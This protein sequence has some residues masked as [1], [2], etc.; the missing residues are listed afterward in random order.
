LLRQIEDDGFATIVEH[1]D[2]AMLAT[3]STGAVALVLTCAPRADAALSLCRGIKAQR[4][5]PVVVRDPR[6]APRAVRARSTWAPTTTWPE[7]ASPRRGGGAGPSDS[8]AH[9]AKAG[10]YAR[11]RSSSTWTGMSRHSTAAR[12]I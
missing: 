12:S 6:P 11:S 1:D 5:V 10:R 9:A 2:E 8:Q 7:S 4:E 3:V